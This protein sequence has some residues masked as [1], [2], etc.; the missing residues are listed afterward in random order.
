MAHRSAV[1]PKMSWFPSQEI[2]MQM[3]MTLATQSGQNEGLDE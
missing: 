3:E 1:S 2:C